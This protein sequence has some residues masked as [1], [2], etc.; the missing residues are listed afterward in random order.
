MF[1]FCVNKRMIYQE[2]FITI[3]IKQ[4]A[5]TQLSC[6]G[7]IALFRFKNNDWVICFI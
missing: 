3:Q 1:C 6:K 5:F 2:F 7:I 4:K